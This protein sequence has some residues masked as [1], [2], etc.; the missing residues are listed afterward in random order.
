VVDG[1]VQLGLPTHIELEVERLES[2]NALVDADLQRRLEARKFR[3]IKGDL[4]EVAGLGGSRLRLTGDL[5][6]HGVSRSMSVEVTARA[7]D[8]DLV[9]V[10][11]EK[12]IDMREFG[13][14]PP[15]FLMFKVEPLVKVRARLV[16]RRQT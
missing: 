10:E 13:L 4:R 6:L 16:A 2:H 9:E 15:R 7:T 11:G 8:G 3:L 5:T 12:V 14:T 1:A